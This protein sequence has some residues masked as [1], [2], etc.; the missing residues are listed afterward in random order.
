MNQV[1]KWL[2]T[3]HA[4]KI[5]IK[6]KEFFNHVACE[7]SRVVGCYFRLH[8]QKNSLNVYIGSGVLCER[9]KVEQ[10]LPSFFG[11]GIFTLID[12][13]PVPIVV[14]ENNIPNLLNGED[15]IPGTDYSNSIS[16]GMRRLESEI[17]RKAFELSSRNNF[18]NVINSPKINSYIEF[19]THEH[20]G[21]CKFFQVW[22]THYSSIRRN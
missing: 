9:L 11:C 22:E 21:P 1:A 5:P 16:L 13:P 12:D 10:E 3:N 19:Y 14:T 15:I 4:A 2:R 7:D 18:L 20:G 8:T 17:I 6:F